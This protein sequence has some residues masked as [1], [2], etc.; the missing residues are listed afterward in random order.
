MKFQYAYRDSKN[1]RHDGFVVA[2]SKDDA[3]KKLRAQGVKPFF[4]APAPGIVNRLQ[5]IGKRGVAIV[6]LVLLC[7][8]LG[9]IA[10]QTT[11]RNRPLA[12]QEE[13]DNAISASM[14]RQPIG[15][16]AVIEKGIRTGWADAFPREG[17]RFLASFA[18]PGVPAGQRNTSEAEI[19]AALSRRVEPAD[20]DSIE[21]RQIK[22]MVDGM[23]DELRKFIADGGSIREYG[24]RLVIRQEEEIGYY[25]KAQRL[26]EQQIEAGKSSAEI[27]AVLDKCNSNLRSMGIKPVTMPERTGKK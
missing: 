23:K 9:V 25:Q 5:G 8:A 18:V 26:I 13:F 16:V 24:H 14:R 7:L 20:S 6:V 15:D 19:T 12:A 17:E 3:F 1:E 22:A 21:V 2:S 10:I 4:V 11:R 27:S